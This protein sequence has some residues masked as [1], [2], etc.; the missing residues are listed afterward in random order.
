[1][2][3]SELA[4]NNQKKPKSCVSPQ[5]SNF[6]NK[7]KGGLC[8]ACFNKSHP[9]QPNVTL[10]RERVLGEPTGGFSVAGM[11]LSPVS[12]AIMI[13]GEGKE[14]QLA[15]HYFSHLLQVTQGMN[16]DCHSLV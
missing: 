11:T 1:M 14:N 9:V 13:E 6:G 8:N 7:Q 2:W 15:A 10:P 16:T 3:L 12:H 5:C 4:S